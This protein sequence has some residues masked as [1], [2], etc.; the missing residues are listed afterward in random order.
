MTEMPSETRWT[1]EEYFALQYPFTA[2]ADEDG[3]Y[4]IL[5][6][7]LPGCITQVECVDEIPAMAEE[8]RRLWIRTE[9]ED[10]EEIPLPSY[11]E[12]HSGKFNV[13]IPRSLHRKL[14]ESA[15]RE[16]VSLNQYVA[17]LLAAGDVAERIGREVNA[18]FGSLRHE[19]DAL[20]AGSRASIHRPTGS[21]QE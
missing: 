11:P 3:G 10:G 1:L 6:P 20:H 2:V 9:Y 12:Q 8:A 14:A 13:R 5:F 19:M 15:E 7:D 21:G 4:T 18:G 17:Q 16:G